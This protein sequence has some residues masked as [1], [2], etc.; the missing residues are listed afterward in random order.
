MLHGRT[1]SELGT[2]LFWSILVPE[3]ERSID[4]VTIV[5]FGVDESELEDRNRIGVGQGSDSRPD[6]GEG[7]DSTAIASDVCIGCNVV[8]VTLEFTMTENLIFRKGFLGNRDKTVTETRNFSRENSTATVR[9]M[10]ARTSGSLGWSGKDSDVLHDARIHDLELQVQSTSR[11]WD[12]VQI[13]RNTFSVISPK[14]GSKSIDCR[15][16]RT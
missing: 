13:T 4:D 15:Q 2:P 12:P 9:P 8:N 6:S 16:S 10:E 5:S 1:N 11:E 14:F 7:N 3:V